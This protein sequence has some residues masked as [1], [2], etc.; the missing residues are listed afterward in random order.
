MIIIIEKNTGVNKLLDMVSLRW[1]TYG[2]TFVDDKAKPM[3]KAPV[4]SAIEK[5]S[6]IYE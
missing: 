3:R 4:I 5:S 1:S 2:L 6:A